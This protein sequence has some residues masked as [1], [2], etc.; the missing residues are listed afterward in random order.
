MFIVVLPYCLQFFLLFFNFVSWLNLYLQIQ[1]VTQIQ[2]RAHDCVRYCIVV[3]EGSWNDVEDAE[4]SD[5]G[6]K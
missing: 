2:F 1:Y 4:V 3:V 6:T 5:A